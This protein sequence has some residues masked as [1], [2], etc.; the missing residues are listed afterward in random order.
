MKRRD[1]SGHTH[2]R[3]HTCTHTHLQGVWEVA[4]SR[5]QL[6]DGGH[7][8]SCKGQGRRHHI[9]RLLDFTHSCGYV[10]R[11]DILGGEEENEGVREGKSFFFFL[12]WSVVNILCVLWYIQYS[13]FLLWEKTRELL[14]NRFS[15]RK[16]SRICGNPV[17]HTH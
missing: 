3:T 5:V 14:E 1:I 10:E 11:R 13:R 17:H 16:L 6:T 8:C 9:A 7:S 15:R 12:K 2:T 4:R